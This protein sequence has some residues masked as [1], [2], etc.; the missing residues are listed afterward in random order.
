MSDLTFIVERMSDA[1]DVIARCMPVDDDA[2]EA[3]LIDR[4]AWLEEL[5]NAASAA[6]A[7][8]TAK[9]SAAVRAR[10]ARLGLPED[11]RGR[12]VAA[13]VALAR[14]ESPFWGRVHTGLA[15]VLVT[16]MPHT[17]RRMHD[18]MLTE[19]RAMILVRETA[20]LTRE[21]RAR[22]DAEICADY[23]VFDGWSDRRFEREAQRRA[24][25]CDPASV[26]A[27]NARAESERRVSVR[28]APDSMAYLTA[29]LPVAQ[30][31]AVKA[32]LMKA[33]DALVASGDGRS[34]S[35][36]EADTLVERA[37]GQSAADAVPVTINLVMT[38][39]AL[40]HGESQPARIPGHGPVPA[41]IARRYLTT[42]TREATAWLRRLYTTPETGDLVA[43]ESKARIFPK[44][45]A[46]L[47]DLRDDTC[48]TPYCDAPIRHHDHALAHDE[49]GPTS[50][51][52]SQGL[53][54]ACNYSKQAPGMQA[55]SVIGLRHTIE[56][57]TPTGHRYASVA[58]PLI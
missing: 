55:K 41:A 15:Q 28:P 46:T 11:E 52:N 47:I 34:R 35:Q 29:L 6:Q 56:L 49:G 10:H 32:G 57:R 53:C 36:I 4:I 43:M 40:L 5:K 51:D 23:A 42:A 9:F 33:A 25:A 16:E 3:A 7:V 39:R 22:I 26:V 13:Q 12:G 44:S 1:V 24:Y 31:V 27:R 18:G 48:R 21:D 2:D 17:L 14:R 54:E 19:K 37:T 38:E 45:M 58:P 8:E 20:V 30:A 50:I